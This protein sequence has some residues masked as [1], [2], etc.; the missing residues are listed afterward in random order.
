MDITDVI[1]KP[2][3]T[4]RSM[5]AVS[6]G[7]FTFA[8]ALRADKNAIKQAVERAF[9][10]EVV[11]VATRVIKGKKKRVGMRRSEVLQSPIKKATVTVKPGQKIDVFEAGA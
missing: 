9:K 4:E 7:K 1:V 5:D 3:I 8:V 10:V 11:S 6:K 2:V